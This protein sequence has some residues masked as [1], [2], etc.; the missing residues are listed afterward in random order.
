MTDAASDAKPAPEG[1][2]APSETRRWPGVWPWAIVTGALALLVATL[3]AMLVLREPEIVEVAGPAPPQLEPTPEVIARAE[4]L[5]REISVKEDALRRQL[6]NLDPPQCIA[7]EAPDSDLLDGIREREAP[8]LRRWQGLLQPVVGPS[9]FMP[10]AEDGPIPEATAA[11]EAV[12]PRAPGAPAAA[13]DTAALRDLLERTSIFVFGLT[14]E[15]RP[16]ISSGSAFFIS[17]TLL[18]TNRHVVADLRPDKIYVAGSALRTA[19]QAE[20]VAI[21]PPGG[22]GTEDFAVLRLVGGKAPAV[23]RMSRQVDKLT[24]VVAAGYPGMSLLSDSGFQDLIRGDLT[25]A[26]DLNMNRGEVRSIRQLGAITQVVHTADVLKGYSGGPLFDGCGR[27]VGV[28]TFIQV[29]REQ[30]AKLNNALA[31]ADLLAFLARNGLQAD[32]D[33]APCEGG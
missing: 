26:P 7:P 22:P 17:D 29:N 27:V 30:A 32:I 15:A 1:Q 23:A 21:S 5:R 9:D 31:M 33:D 16:S 13:L 25:A 12:A 2:A 8:N 10:P 4:A 3:I 14:Q 19:T 20:T 11:D 28:N 6:A 24:P 18:V